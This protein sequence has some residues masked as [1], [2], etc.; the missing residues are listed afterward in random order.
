MFKV[1]IRSGALLSVLTISIVIVLIMT[2]LLVL[3]VSLKTSFQRSQRIDRLNRNAGS[4]LNLLLSGATF[5]LNED[6]IIDLY[7]NKSDSVYLHRMAWGIYDVYL[8][9]AFSNADTIKKEAIIGNLLLSEERFALYLADH[10][11]PL[12]ISGE[13]RIA[14]DVL[15]PEAGIRKANIEG[16]AFKGSKMVYGISKTS[17]Q[18]LPKLNEPILTDIDE[19]LNNSTERIYSSERHDFFNLDSI[20]NPFNKAVFYIYN[21]KPLVLNNVYLKGNVIVISDSAIQIDS[22]AILKDIQIYAPSVTIK[23]GFMG[24]VQVF[25]RD[26]INIHKNV[27]LEYPSVLGL[28]TS[29][30]KDH[31]YEDSPFV[32]VAEY[33]RINGIIF[34]TMADKEIPFPIIKIDKNAEIYGQVFASGM[35]QL[36][37]EIMGSTITNGFILKTSSTLYEN[38][39]LN[40]TMDSN[41]LSEY[42]LG[43]KLINKNSVMGILKWL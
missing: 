1:K 30:Q 24:S 21:A 8:V 35:L 16:Q 2:G 13:T 10:Q 32:N 20:D 14:G 5:D 38:F 17:K 22:S 41:K 43:S 12:S 7:E 28:V 29:N 37:G 18:E 34:S 42:Y 26:S 39:V 27:V 23:E 19:L 31:Q 11:R 33:S 15:I 36:Q 6:S 40:G 3:S 4:G 9:H 25:S